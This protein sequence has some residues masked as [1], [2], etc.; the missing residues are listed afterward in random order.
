MT[1]RSGQKTLHSLWYRLRKL[2]AGHNI[3][4]DLNPPI[5]E[6]KR[7]QEGVRNVARALLSANLPAWTSDRLKEIAPTEHWYFSNKYNTPHG[8]RWSCLVRQLPEQLQALFVYFRP[9]K[10]LLK[11]YPEEKTL[12]VK[13]RRSVLQRELKAALNEKQP[14]SFN[15][16]W[17][18]KNSI[19]VYQRILKLASIDDDFSWWSFIKDLGDEWLEKFNP[20]FS[21]RDEST[22]DVK[23]LAE[24]H[25]QKELYLKKRRAEL[26]G[27]LQKFLAAENPESFSPAWIQANNKSL[28]H[29]IGNL[30]KSDSELNWY[31]FVEEMGEGWLVKF[32]FKCRS[33]EDYARKLVILVKAAKV[34]TWN[35]QWLRDKHH[36]FLTCVQRQL[37]IDGKAAEDWNEF[38]AIIDPALL[39][40]YEDEAL[41]KATAKEEH[42]R[43]VIESAAEKLTQAVV[44]NG[45]TTWTLSDIADIDPDAHKAVTRRDDVV[46][47][48][49]R[50]CLPLLPDNVLSGARSNVPMMK[51]VFWAE[52]VRRSVNGNG[53]DG[54]RIRDLK[55]ESL[56]TELSKLNGKMSVLLSFLPP[57]LSFSFVPEGVQNVSRARVANVLTLGNDEPEKVHGILEKTGYLE[58]G[59]VSMQLLI[60]LRDE[61]AQ[62]NRYAVTIAESI[63]ED[64]LGRNNIHIPIK[65]GCVAEIL[66]RLTE[67]DDLHIQIIRIAYSFG[68]ERETVSLDKPAGADSD[69]SFGEQIGAN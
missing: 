3:I 11:L 60:L 36:I 16:S 35:L 5:P 56:R 46:L 10:A 33:L 26:Q 45:L 39:D 6:D 41:V 34:E 40:T 50:R 15:A 25:E 44:A 2:L 23:E 28:Y 68:K 12:Y 20:R 51:Y 55:D 7:E 14:A 64:Y 53:H 62:G 65:R 19:C 66:F 27:Q 1:K 8:I 59:K 47:V 18:E 9:N 24:Y 42:K 43:N 63:L 21:F 29:E 17:I 52:R 54:W 32:N 58:S 31:C 69:R 4:L 49:I 30:M 61:I 57:E 48:G 67:T 13:S 22:L 37:K 38:L